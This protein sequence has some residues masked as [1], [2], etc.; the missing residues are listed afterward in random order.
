PFDRPLLLAY[1]QWLLY[2]ASDKVLIGL[3]PIG[4]FKNYPVIRNVNDRSRPSSNEFRFSAYTEFLQPFSDNLFAV[5]RLWGEYRIFE[6]SPRQVLRMRFRTGL[7]YNA[8]QNISVQLLNEV[9][10][11]I[12]NFNAFQSFDHNRVYVQFTYAPH[13]IFRIEA[14][15]ILAYRLPRNATQVYPESNIVLN[16]AIILGNSRQKRHQDI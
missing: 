8:N 6:Q 14:A 13:Q 9:F 15:Y 4:Y 11:N 1:R 2:R 7:R 3:S 5:C 12:G 16:T 10:S